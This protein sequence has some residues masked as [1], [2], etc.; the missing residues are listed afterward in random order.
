[1]LKMFL[2]ILPAVSS[3]PEKLDLPSEG[4]QEHH[5]S[6]PTREQALKAIQ[7]VKLPSGVSLT[8]NVEPVKKVAKPSEQQQNDTDGNNEQYW[9]GLGG[10][11][12]L[13]GYGGFGPWINQLVLNYS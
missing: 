13:G 11:G 9:G 3:I 7:N 1:M 12:G 8:G 10:F 5:A 4:V 2:F 6:L